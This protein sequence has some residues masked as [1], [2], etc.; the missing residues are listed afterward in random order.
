[1]QGQSVSLH[2]GRTFKLPRYTSGSKKSVSGGCE[3]AAAGFVLVECLRLIHNAM[4]N[5][6]QLTTAQKLYALRP[7]KAGPNSCVARRRCQRVVE[8]KGGDP[9]TEILRS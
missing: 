9:A 1:M 3:P 8:H 7:S 2:S 6:S 5:A 4:R